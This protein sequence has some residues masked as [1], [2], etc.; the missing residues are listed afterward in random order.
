LER[1]TSVL[2]LL[3]Q[4]ERKREERGE[5]P[6]GSDE[7]EVAA[8]TGPA[9]G[10]AGEGPQARE[11]AGSSHPTGGEIPGPPP[12]ARDEGAASGVDDRP[13]VP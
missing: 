12:A 8:A 10:R 6:P 5:I 9:D 13:D 11:A 4:L 3:N 1:G 2:G 7:E